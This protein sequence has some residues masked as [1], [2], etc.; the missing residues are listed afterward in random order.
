MV[1]LGQVE[2]RMT[3]SRSLG[4]SSRILTDKRTEVTDQPE[5]IGAF[6]ERDPTLGS[7]PHTNPKKDDM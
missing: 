7:S 5:G 3:N 4:R 1:Q 6:R 2:G